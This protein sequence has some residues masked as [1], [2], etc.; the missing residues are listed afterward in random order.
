MNPTAPAA[1]SQQ[2]NERF[3]GGADDLAMA[4]NDQCLLALAPDYS[5]CAMS[6]IHALIRR[7]VAGLR[8]QGVP[9]LGMQGD[10]L[11]GAGCVESVDAAAVTLG[12][13]GQAPRFVSAFLNGEIIM[14]DST[15][16][17]IHAG[18]QAAEKNIPFM[19][20]RGILG[21]DLVTHR[22]DWQ[23]IDNPFSTDKDPILLVP[24]IKPDVAL[25]HAPMADSQGNVW[26]GK[27]RELMLMSHAAKRTLVSVERVCEG[28]LL[29]NDEQAAGTIPALYIDKLAVIPAGGHPVGLFGSYEEDSQQLKHYAAASKTPDGFNDYL[30]EFVL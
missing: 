23:V 20:L 28:N 2:I 29:D 4:I 5:G 9:Q 14:R 7:A 18:L 19:P 11:I 24:Q 3:V 13:Y 15:C 6:V 30:K 10:L 16:P 12:E 8:L 27:R 17:V 25:F 26:I 21:S 22:P 1:G